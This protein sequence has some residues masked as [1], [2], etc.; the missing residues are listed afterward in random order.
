[1]GICRSCVCSVISILTIVVII[2]GIYFGAYSVEGNNTTTAN[3]STKCDENIN[4]NSGL[5]ECTKRYQDVFREC[6]GNIGLHSARHCDTIYTWY[7]SWK[8]L[9]TCN[10]A[11]PC[12]V[13]QT[14]ETSQPS[15]WRNN[16]EYDVG[17]VYECYTNNECT[18]I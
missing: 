7:Y 5:C 8:I 1:M 16:A 18:K 9:D 4:T 11:I 15:E 12:N 14:F 6:T 17:T 10:N 2:S 13:Y 3:I